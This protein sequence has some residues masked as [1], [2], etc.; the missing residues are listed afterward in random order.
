M[1]FGQQVEAVVDASGMMEAIRS[2]EAGWIMSSEID[3]KAQGEAEVAVEAVPPADFP[4]HVH[5][6]AVPGAQPKLLMTQYLG[7]FYVPGCTPPELLERWSICE[8]LA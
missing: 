8:D 2:H 3:K 6:G 1:T 7:R 4:R 5:L